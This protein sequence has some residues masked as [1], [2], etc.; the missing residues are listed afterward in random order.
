MRSSTALLIGLG[1]FLSG[2]SNGP[3]IGEASAPAAVTLL[4][5]LPPPGGAATAPDGE[6]Y[7]IAPL[8]KLKIIVAGVDDLSGTFQTDTRDRFVLPYIG[9]VDATRLT[10]ADLAGTLERK[11]AAY[12]KDP[13]V[14]VN[15]DEASSLSFSVDGQ[16][17]QPGIYPL[18]ARMTLLRAVAAA[19]G[20][21]EFARL[22]D[23]VI[24]R[25][26]EGR[27]M[28]GLYDLNAI[29]HGNY[30]DPS[31]FA[32]DVIVVGD[33]KGRRQFQ[34]FLQS[35]PLFTTPVILAL[36]RIH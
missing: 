26:V 10:A 19:K 27:P 32:G 33:A 7:R 28:A 22:D 6:A 14:A 20:A 31:V 4:K 35:I 30:T 24:F 34:Q 5:E 1:L 18:T 9:E 8:D 21:S 16:V 29:R 13:H 23:V 2:C 25:T 12:V 15:I 3:R 11:F 17:G 36:E